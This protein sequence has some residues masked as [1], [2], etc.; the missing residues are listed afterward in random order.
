M[1][2]RPIRII[3]RHGWTYPP[4]EELMACPFCRSS[5]IEE[6]DDEDDLPE[7]WEPSCGG[8]NQKQN[9]QV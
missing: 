4:Y 8:N 6:R 2:S 9:D 5:D 3:E 7:V 1:F